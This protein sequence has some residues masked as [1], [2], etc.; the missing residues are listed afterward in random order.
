MH[1]PAENLLTPEVLRRLAWA[2]PDPV[3]ES[4]IAAA[5]AEQGARPWQVVAVAQPIAEAFVESAQT[6]A[7]ASAAAS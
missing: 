1:L 2:P 5:L 3:D 7:T 6:A 4:T